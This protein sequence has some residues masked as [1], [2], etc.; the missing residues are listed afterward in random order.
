MHRDIKPSN[1][2]VSTVEGRERV[3]VADFGIA[4]SLDEEATRTNGDFEYSPHYVAPERFY[5]SLPDHRCDIYSLGATL[6]RLLTASHPYPNRGDRELIAA[7]LHEPAPVPTRIRPELPPAIDSVIATAM[8]KEPGDRYQSCAALAAAAR[9]ALTGG[10]VAEVGRARAAP[11]AGSGPV[12]G[13]ETVGGETV[14]DEAVGGET[15]GSRSAGDEPLGGD[16]GDMPHD[17]STAGNTTEGT[18]TRGSTTRG[19]TT[20]GSSTRGSSTRGD[21][22]RGDE[23]TGRRT[24]DSEPDG[25]RADGG[26]IADSAETVA[27][28]HNGDA[29]ARFT[30]RRAGMLGAAAF[31]LVLLVLAAGWGF[32]V[33]G[34][35]EPPPG[36]GA[37]ILDGAPSTG[38]LTARCHWI[39]Q[40]AA[41][42]GTYLELPSGDS[43][44]DAPDCILN[45]GDR[46]HAV[47]T[48]QRAIALCHQIP[49]DVSGV[50]D[51]S[52]KFTIQQLQRAAG[53]EADGIYGPQTRSAVLRWPLW[54]EE[55]GGFA[56]TCRS[57]G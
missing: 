27:G 46:T 21:E 9:A 43:S 6:H 48:V 22:T 55:N 24:A 51:S 11:S 31:T 40:R 41:D 8:A 38:Y 13:D 36:T 12:S 45:L 23:T 2:L 54:R 19:S 5:S 37:V 39:V 34:D 53:V 32:V 3:L 52:T 35:P 17:S 50:Y 10:R 42:D 25:S 20:R 18:A 29:P 47:S 56:G 49:V 26:E 16:V 14:G 1:L 28:R 4:R 30:P 15:V 7:H 33:R 57:V 44:R